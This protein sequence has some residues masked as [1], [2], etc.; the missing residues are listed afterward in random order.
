MTR[1]RIPTPSWERDH[2]GFGESL[3][4]SRGQLAALGIIVVLMIAA[5]GVGGYAL[6]D[7]YYLTPHQLPGSTALAVGDTKYSVREF[8]NRTKMFAAQLSGTTN[9][10]IIIPAMDQQLQREAVELQFAGE[11]NVSASEDDIRKEIATTIGITADDP[12]FD[13]RFQEE[14]K[15]TGLTE[16]Q[17]RNMATA[18]VLS[19]NLQAAF[20]AALAP[21]YDSIHYR[22]I[23]V[24]D[25]ATADNLKAQIEGGAD[26][27]ALAAANSNDTATKTTGGDTGWT[28]RGYLSSTLENL[29]F[30]LDTNQVIT[31]PGTSNVTIYQLLEKDP[32]HAVDDTKKTKLG[33]NDLQK[34]FSD[35]LAAVTVD[36]QMNLNTGN[37][38]K[39]NYVF[40]HAAL[41]AQ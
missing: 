40:D 1:R 19:T 7:K 36:D 28:P 31:S 9:A 33:Q 5:L 11:K 4:G 17:Y 16:Q 32:A 12:N 21:T 26:F 38:D 13:T 23:V 20:V 2:R 8:T 22:Q 41:T 15:N 14:L 37:A 35:K 6:F 27:A 34:Y 39:I 18:S 10:Q 29:L 24:A 3:S 30:S 25:Q